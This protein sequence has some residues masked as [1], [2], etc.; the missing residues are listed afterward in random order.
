ML[1]H[2]L[3]Y[4]LLILLSTQ[5][6]KATFTELK[7]IPIPEQ[8]LKDA[9][10]AY[11]EKVL[12][13]EKRQRFIDSL[14]EEDI[15][16]LEEA[17]NQAPLEIKAIVSKILKNPEETTHYRELLLTGPS[18]SG[19]STLARA[20]A[21]KLG[22][23][24]IV[25]TGPSLL[26]HFRDQAAEKVA[27]TF[28]DWK[29]NT[30]KP[31]IVIDEIN[32]LT[33][34]HTSEHSDTKHTAMQLWTLLDEYSKDKDFLLI[35]TTNVTKKMPHQLQS[36]FR[37]KSFYIDNPSQD[38]LIRALIFRIQHMQLIQAE[39]C[40][41]EYLNELASKSSDFSRRD[42]EALIEKALLLQYIKNPEEPRLL[43]KD[44][45]EQAY[46]YLE[47]EKEML[48][49][50]S[51]QTTDEER[52]HR[53]NLAQNDKHFVES[54][55]MQIRLAEWNMLYQS[56]IKPIE[57]NQSFNSHEAIKQLNLA[58]TIVF[59]K[60]TSFAKFKFVPYTSCW[61]WRKGV[62]EMLDVENFPNTKS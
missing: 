60:K 57:K 59:P 47:R 39:D 33:D 26:G 1:K 58:K 31:V 62:T 42:V 5:I 35:G 43:T 8:E 34:D 12:K 16:L 2:V 29:N 9:E 50:F 55:D 38:A 51:E 25:V 53:E 13:E 17:F 19:K 21:Y 56:L 49:D 14:K 28:K 20:I 22:R 52:R 18:G 6:T 10:Q 37:G 15:P 4:T 40:N 54:Q 61:G 45:F 7:A 11:K 46:V 3:T 48:W 27:K 44:C 41:N 32:A 24:V 36:R 30:D 23:K